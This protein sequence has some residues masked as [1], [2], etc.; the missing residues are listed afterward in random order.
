[1]AQAYQLAPQQSGVVGRGGAVGVDPATDVGGLSPDEFKQAFRRHPAGV[2]VI[3]A[4]N[5]NGPVGLTATSVFSVSAE[6]ALF[7]FSLSSASPT[8]RAI[9]CADTVVIHLLGAHQVNAARL[10]SSRG[11]DRFA[12]P[13]S[14]SRLETGEPYLVDAPIW[15]RGRICERLQMQVG[16][17]IVIACH[18]LQAHISPDQEY[19]PLVYHDRAWHEIGA[20][21]KLPE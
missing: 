9:A 2:A 18:A 14:W 11:V 10:F 7:S 15:V 13:S 21:S 19:A 4:D 1:M 5:G 12:D 20:K 8:A 6:P 3:T 17:S 16:G